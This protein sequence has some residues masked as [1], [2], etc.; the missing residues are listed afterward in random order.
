MSIVDVPLSPWQQSV[1]AHRTK[2]WFLLAGRRKGKSFV[3]ARKLIEAALW[4]YPTKLFALDR[5]TAADNWRHLVELVEPF[6][7]ADQKW[8]PTNE[9]ILEFRNDDTNRVGSIAR[10]P[11]AGKKALGVAGEAKVML[12]DEVQHMLKSLYDRSRPMLST[13]R[14]LSIFTLTPPDS[15]ESYHASMWLLEMMNRKDRFPSW[16]F[17]AD[18]T[19][20]EDI[21]WHIR[22]QDI[23]SGI[24]PLPFK[25]YVKAAEDILA[26]DREIL[27]DEVYERE[28]NLRWS[29]DI[30]TLVFRGMIDGVHRSTKWEYNPA[31]PVYW[32][33]DLGGGAAKT[34]ILF[35]QRDLVIVNGAPVARYWFFDELWTQS[36]AIDEMTLINEALRYSV[37][38]SYTL[39]YL[40]ASP[41]PSQRPYHVPTHVVVDTRATAM[42]RAVLDSRLVLMDRNVKI[43]EGIGRMRYYMT[44]GRLGFHPRCETL[45]SN[46]AM[47]SR[48]AQGFPTDKDNDAANAASYGIVLTEDYFGDRLAQ[49]RENEALVEASA[50]NLARTVAVL[51]L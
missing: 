27:S 30:N 28:Y 42:K 29:L 8:S 45:Y 13:L 44:S 47:W 18:P 25:R 41:L 26:E 39:G 50:P 23:R 32:C 38:S 19:M 24:K 51:P 7:Q 49:G 34:V 16:H 40:S 17:T 31:L 2:N 20:P 48:D 14:G 43:E 22:Y 35:F 1:W 6:R 37:D 3:A 15:P 12:F 46:M 10:I 4:G 5:G 21:A 36:A 11:V 33:I 9:G